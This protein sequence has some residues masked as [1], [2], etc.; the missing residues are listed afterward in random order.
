MLFD[1]RKKRE[2]APPAK[3][4]LPIVRSGRKDFRGEIVIKVIAAMPRTDRQLNEDCCHLV[5]I[6]KLRIISSPYSRAHLGGSADLHKPLVS[7]A[8]WRP[9]HLAPLDTTKQH[10]IT[11]KIPHGSGTPGVVRWR[12]GLAGGSL[13]YRTAWSYNRE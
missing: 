6:R 7:F 8:A 10:L 4:P 3:R 13:Y 2:R 1:G 12:F 11:V 9:L 5:G